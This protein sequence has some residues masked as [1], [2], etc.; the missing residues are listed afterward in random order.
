MS[1]EYLT[2]RFESKTSSRS[3]VGFLHDEFDFSLSERC[4]AELLR[5][6]LAN[7]TFHFFL[8]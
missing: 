6:V 3:V 5:K 4:E 1:E 2:W 7:K 8:W